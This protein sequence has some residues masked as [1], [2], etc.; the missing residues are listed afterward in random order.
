[1]YSK[2]KFLV[3][4]YMKKKISIEAFIFD[5]WK[6]LQGHFFLLIFR[7][8]FFYDCI[9]FFFLQKMKSLIAKFNIYILFFN[10]F[11][12][13]LELISIVLLILL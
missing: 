10:K 5:L 8:Y 11:R 7:V 12:S 6:L 1:M 3:L 9:S 13:H 2:I 4:S